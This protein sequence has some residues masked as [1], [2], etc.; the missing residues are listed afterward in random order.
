LYL[1]RKYETTSFAQ[2]DAYQLRQGCSGRL[3]FKHCVD[4]PNSL[5]FLDEKS[6]IVHIK[7]REKSFKASSMWGYAN[8]H[9]YIESLACV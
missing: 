4:I 9:H 1:L 5:I 2:F 8:A 7:K 3:F 6:E